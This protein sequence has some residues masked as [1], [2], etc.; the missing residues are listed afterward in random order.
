M[1]AKLVVCWAR[2]W[3]RRIKANM[4]EMRVVSPTP[5]LG[6]IVASGWGMSCMDLFSKRELHRW[7]SEVSLWILKASDLVPRNSIQ[8]FLFSTPKVHRD[9]TRWSL[10]WLAMI[11]I[12]L[13]S[14]KSLLSGSIEEKVK[15]KWTDSDL[16]NYQKTVY[17]LIEPIGIFIPQTNCQLTF[18][19]L[20]DAIGIYIIL[21]L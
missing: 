19:N 2:A 13:Q 21:P 16:T 11:E 5:S 4:V 12:V 14:I 15:E 1:L 6:N 3:P 8:L 9:T 17:N 20:I 10:Y 18:Y 7:P